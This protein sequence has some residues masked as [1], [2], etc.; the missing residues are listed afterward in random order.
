MSVKPIVLGIIIKIIRLSF[1]GMVN[2][3]KYYIKE[4]DIKTYNKGG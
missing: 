2:A 1:L 3:L 4:V